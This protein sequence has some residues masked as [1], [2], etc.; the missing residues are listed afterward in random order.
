M[1]RLADALPDL[2]SG[3]ESALVQ[4]GRGDLLNQLGDASIARW[5]Y[6][7]FS[8]T[9]YVFLGDEAFEPTSGERLSLWDELGVNVDCDERGRVR[10]L[11][12]FDGRRVSAELER[13]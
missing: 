8:D 4:V 1:K 2:V 5:T 9:T 12:V 13:P 7:D 6:D 10:G 3:L 11:E